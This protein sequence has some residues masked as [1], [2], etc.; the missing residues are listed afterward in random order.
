METNSSSRDEGDTEPERA[1]LVRRHFASVELQQGERFVPC[2]VISS[3]KFADT[4][5]IGGVFLGQ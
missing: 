1:T 4:V 5:G 3:K 2:A